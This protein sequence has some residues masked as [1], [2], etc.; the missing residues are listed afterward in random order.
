MELMDDDI[1]LAIFVKV[2]VINVK[3]ERATPVVEV[4]IR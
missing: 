2:V 1:P 4:S 3:G